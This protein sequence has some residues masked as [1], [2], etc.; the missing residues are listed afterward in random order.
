SFEVAHDTARRERRAVRR[1]R[2]DRATNRGLGE[3]GEI[4]RDPPMLD[5]TPVTRLGVG[6]IERA[7]LAGRGAA[8]PEPE[9]SR[10]VSGPAGADD[11]GRAASLRPD[12]FDQPSQRAEVTP[13]YGR[14]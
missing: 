10:V 3:D 11:R 4:V 1:C 13:A 7:L 8:I 2:E 5:A 12:D 9:S 6:T 14:S